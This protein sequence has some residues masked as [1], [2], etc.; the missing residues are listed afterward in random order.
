ML[1]ARRLIYSLRKSRLGSTS[2][3]LAVLFLLLL[4]QGCSSPETPDPTGGGGGKGTS[5]S[6][7]KSKTDLR[8]GIPNVGNT[9]YMNSVLQVIARLYPDIFSRKSSALAQAGK[10]LVDAIKDHKR[11][12]TRE[13]AE[14]FLD[15]LVATGWPIDGGRRNSQQ[16]PQE[17]L[18]HI[19]DKLGVPGDISLRETQ[20]YKDSTDK[21]KSNPIDTKIHI[22]VG[23]SGLKEEDKSYGN[24]LQMVLDQYFLEEEVDL[25]DAKTGKANKTTRI[26]V[27]SGILAVQAVRFGWN[28]AAADSYKAQEHLEKPFEL[29][30]KA[31]HQYTD[32]GTPPKDVSYA[33]RAF[34]LHMEGNSP[35]GG[36]YTAYVRNCEGQWILYNDDKEVLIKPENEAEKMASEAYLYFYKEAGASAAPTP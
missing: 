13:E 4:G 15:A 32:S 19:F 36:H 18:S 33:L 22:L 14:A 24:T 6:D 11:D 31:G 34:I 27:P 35:K 9:C 28:K 1:N 21:E 30:V 12:A 10:A 8:G 3:A 25:T 29:T 2:R 16:D 7:P 23:I 17:L 5:S 26:Q 20:A